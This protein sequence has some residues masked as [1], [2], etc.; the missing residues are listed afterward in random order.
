MNKETEDF[1]EFMKRREQAAKA[2][3]SGDPQPLDEISVRDDPATF[4]GPG[5]DFEKGAGDVS[6]RYIKDAAS[7]EEGSETHFEIL[8]MAASGDIAY[9]V[10]FQRA[11]ARLKGKSEP[12]SFNL[13][14]TEIFRRE[15]GEWKLAHR[16]A[17]ELKSESKD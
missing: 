4:Y 16:H 3:V 14:I 6:K 5:G 11:E 9:W 17:D 10:G 15:N 12:V 7:F 1:K 13:R 8:Q 2:Y